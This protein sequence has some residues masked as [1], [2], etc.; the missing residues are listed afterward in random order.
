MASK[1]ETIPSPPA[2]P[3]PL[4]IRCRRC[5]CADLRVVQT[6]RDNGVVRRRRVCR[7]CGTQMMT[8]EAAAKPVTN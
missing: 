8:T 5:N 1:P 4:G 6:I 2:D 3:P 7:H